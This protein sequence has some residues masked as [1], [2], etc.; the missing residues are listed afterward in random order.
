MWFADWMAREKIVFGI[1]V[2]FEWVGEWVKS[3][4]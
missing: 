2:G 4:W 3:G 1:L